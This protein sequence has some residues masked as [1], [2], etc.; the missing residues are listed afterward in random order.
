[1]RFFF[2]KFSLPNKLYYYNKAIRQH[3]SLMYKR[4]SMKKLILTTSMV[5]LAISVCIAQG[6]KDALKYLFTAFDTTSSAPAMTTLLPRLDM[7]VQQN[8]TSWASYFYSAYARIK[9]SLKL[10][11]KGV[12]DQYLDAADAMLTKAG[13][14]SPNNEE[15]FILQAYSGKARIAADPGGRWKKYGDVYSG[16]ITK[17]KKINPENPRIYFLEGMDPFWRPKI[18]GGGKSKAKPYFE[19]AGALFSKESKADILKPYW[20][21]EANEEFLR[22]CDK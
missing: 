7:Y 22:Q 5:G 6:N 11:D 13:Q 19:K 9:L 18:W 3:E 10:T 4:K 2:G 14:L 21:E 15:I 8:S 12:R 1:M 16:F 20:G 17:A